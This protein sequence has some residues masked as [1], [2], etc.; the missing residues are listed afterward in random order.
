MSE[1]CRSRVPKGFT[2]VELLVVV[3]VIAILIALLMPALTRAREQANRVKCA[4]NMRQIM[5]GAIMYSHDNKKGVYIWRY[6]STDDDL[7]PLYPAYIKD[8][9]VAVCPNTDNV[10][11]Q[12][13]HLRDNA[14]RGPSDNRGGHSYEVRGWMWVDIIFPDG[15]SFVREKI[16]NSDGTSY[17]G[18]PMKAAK[19]FKTPSKVCLLMDGDDDA[20]ADTNNWPEK[21]DNHGAAGMNVSYMDGHVEWTPTGRPVLEAFINGYYDPGV[22]TAIYTKYGLQ[23]SGNRFT[24]TW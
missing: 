15:I 2:L 24:W 7:S 12:T 18:E 4:S 6:P 3:G 20:N 17:M 14:V 1:S 9:Q 21:G 22:S 13:S 5:L 8:F 19:R 11:N 10:V 23:K 16:Y